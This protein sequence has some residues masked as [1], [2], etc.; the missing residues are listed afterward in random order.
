V[1]RQDTWSGLASHEKM[2][3]L[4][5]NSRL[6]VIENAGHMSTMERPAEVSTAMVQW[7]RLIA[8]S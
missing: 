4:I 5:P 3:E 1:G 8:K 2:G 6:V 7:F